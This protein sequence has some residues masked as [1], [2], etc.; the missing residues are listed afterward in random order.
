MQKMTC[1][2]C[3]LTA[4]T[5]DMELKIHRDKKHGFESRVTDA[6][7]RTSMPMDALQIE[8]LRKVRIA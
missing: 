1:S 3:G 7:E 8:N 4:F 6:F 5:S 2:K